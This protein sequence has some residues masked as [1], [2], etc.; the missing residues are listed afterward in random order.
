MTLA[1]S[2]TTVVV[3]G[4]M[5]LVSACKAATATPPAPRNTFHWLK[6]Y[7]QVT[8]LAR[9]SDKMILAYF[10]SSDGEPW[11][12]KLEAD[13]L[14]TEPFK[15]WANEHIIPFQVDF[16]VNKRVNSITKAQN[17]AM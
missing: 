2:R 3:A 9:K 12:E 8:A 6:S 10:C 15:N 13:V 17:D 5:L 1:S 16:P 11:T 4:L 7:D 14:S